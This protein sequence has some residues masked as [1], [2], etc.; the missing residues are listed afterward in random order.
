MEKS[1]P[2]EIERE[3]ESIVS[4]FEEVGN[5]HNLYTR[6]IGNIYAIEFHIRMNGAV[7]LHDAHHTITAIEAKLKERYGASTHIIIHVEPYKKP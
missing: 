4:K 7:P 3:I 5:L 1:L 6:K 2:E